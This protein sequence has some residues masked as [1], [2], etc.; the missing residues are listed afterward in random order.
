MAFSPNINDREKTK[1]FNKN[2]K[3]VVRVGEEPIDNT[4][5][6]QTIAVTTTKQKITIAESGAY[7][8]GHHTTAGKLYISGKDDVSASSRYLIKNGTTKFLAAAGFT[9]W[10]V[11]SGSFNIFLSRTGIQ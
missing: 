3:A 11:A 2:G 4:F 5:V 7:I 6:E 10:V 9:F 1:F 8:L